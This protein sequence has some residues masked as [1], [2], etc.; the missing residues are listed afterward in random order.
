MTGD[1]TFSVRR[2]MS[3]GIVAL[4]LLC[5]G[6]FG[7]GVFASLSGAVIAA[8]QVESEGGDR[9]VEHVDGGT[10][11]A[12]L[13]RDGDR[14][15]ASDVLVRIDGVLLASEAAVLESELYDLVARRNRL[16]AEFRASDAII[17]DALLVEA[18]RIDPAV[19]TAVEGHQRLFEAR[20]KTRAGFIAQLGERIEQTRKQIAGF[21]AQGK[22]LMRQIGLMTE[23]LDTQ[24]SLLERELTSKPLVL[25]LQRGTA[26]LEGQAGDIAARVAAAHGRIAEIEAQIL[27]SIFSA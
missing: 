3:L 27:Q 17:W 8:G 10:V 18:V 21:E 19:R 22:A 13:V 7:W 26:A 6:L 11:A 5:G 23:E 9:A 14:V 20:R 24:Q 12:V 15:A 2:G 4:A 25:E 16:E 1:R